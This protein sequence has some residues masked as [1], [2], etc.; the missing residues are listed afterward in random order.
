MLEFYAEWSRGVSR[1]LYAGPFMATMPDGT[2]IIGME[3]VYNGDPAQGEKE[4]APL[5]AIGT[6]IDDGV[7]LQDY[8]VLQTHEDATAAHGIRSYAKNGMVKEF[9]QGLVERH[10]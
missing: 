3:V 7:K 10:D 2:G 1:E 5:R 6:L 9:T 8:K 4:L